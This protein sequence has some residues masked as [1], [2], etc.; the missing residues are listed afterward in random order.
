MND[1]DLSPA[2]ERGIELF[3]VVVVV[4]LIVYFD[5]HGLLRGLVEPPIKDFVHWLGWFAR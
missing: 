4:G 2:V 3:S 5:V 1:D